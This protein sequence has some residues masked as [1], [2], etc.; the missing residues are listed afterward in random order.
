MTMVCAGC[1]DPILD[2]EKNTL[3]IHHDVINCDILFNGDDIDEVMA[4]YAEHEMICDKQLYFHEEHCTKC[5]RQMS[6]V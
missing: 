4:N 5:A 6:A 1:L 2:S 3:H